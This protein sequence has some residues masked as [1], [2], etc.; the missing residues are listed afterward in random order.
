MEDI[1]Q[2]RYSSLLKGFLTQI[3]FLESFIEERLCQSSSSSLRIHEYFVGDS[4]EVNMFG[5]FLAS[6]GVDS[7]F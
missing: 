3:C 2:F 6:K 7:V 4:D 1:G 5:A